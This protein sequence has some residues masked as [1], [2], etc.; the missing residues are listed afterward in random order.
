MPSGYA[1]EYAVLTLIP[2]MLPS[3]PV[4]AEMAWFGASTATEIRDT[5]FFGYGM[6]ILP[7]IYSP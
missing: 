1:L 3:F 5:P 6:P 2:S 4:K 7:M